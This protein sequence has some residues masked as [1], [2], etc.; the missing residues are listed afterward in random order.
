MRRFLLLGAKAAVSA[1]LLSLALRG[2][3]WSAVGQR[4]R[5]IDPA[6][7][8]AT[9][10][11]LSAQ[12]FIAAL[13]WREIAQQCGIALPVSRATRLSFIGAFFS[14][15]LPST[16]GGDAARIWLLARGGGGW[17][18]AT[19]SVLI[20]RA[21][22]AAA[23]AVLVLACLPWTLELVRNPIGRIAL[24]LI[25]VGT[26][27]GF[28]VFL[29]LGALRHTW[30]ARFWVT[31]HLTSAAAIAGKLVTSPRAGGSVAALSILVHL[32]SVTAAW[33]TA[34][35]LAVPLDF[36]HALFLVPPIILIAMIPIS[37]AGWGVR[38][39]AMV[40]AFAYAGLPESDGLVVSLLF[41][42]A[43]FVVGAIGGVVW[44]ASSDRA[45]T[46]ATPALSRE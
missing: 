40:V 4:L 27:T 15:T 12:L 13:R 45:K 42:A 7:L 20:D 35:A 37:I 9:V 18:A 3:G 28:L 24:L 1:L 25:G 8:L 14:Q 39:N 5:D 16:V 22:G 11:I 10:L 30:V 2:V 38:E 43:F 6:W 44:I 41:G 29:A 23:L 32:M 19:Y 31:H 36:A 34:K 17:K 33:G 46:W 21:A 26:L